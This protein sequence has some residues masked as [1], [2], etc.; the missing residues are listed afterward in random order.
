[1]NE[2]LVV[3]L[4]LLMVLVWLISGRPTIFN[5]RRSWEDDVILAAQVKR[6]RKNMRGVRENN[7]MLANVGVR[8]SVT[9][10]K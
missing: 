5:Y 9:R 10:I 7:P 2:L 6:T 1:M 3:V 4:A 8:K